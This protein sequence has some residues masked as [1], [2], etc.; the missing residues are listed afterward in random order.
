[1]E[2][3]QRMN[4]QEPNSFKHKFSFVNGITYHYVDEGEE[5]ND[6]II[7]LHGFPD[8]WYGW[9]YQIPYLVSKG[10]RV[11]A[12]DLR[13]YGQTDAPRC[14]PNDLLQYGSKNVSK[15][16][17]E[18]MD[19]LKVKKAIIFGHD[20]GGFLAWRLCI[21]YPERVKAIVSVCTPYIPPNDNYISLES[22]AE[23]L[24][25]LQYQ[26]YLSHPKA[27]IELDGNIERCFKAILRTSTVEDHI[28]LFDG[29]SM[30]GHVIDGVEKSDLISQKELDYYVAQY[31]T[32]GF[33]GGLN[34]YKTRK[35]NFQDEKG[36]RK[37][38][39]HPALMVTAGKDL[40]IHPSTTKNMHKFCKDLSI[41]NIENSGH[42]VMLEQANQLHEYLDEFLEY[43]KNHES[44]LDEKQQH[45]PYY[46]RYQSKENKAKL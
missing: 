2:S 19:Q 43:V 35:V 11:I 45:R 13:G 20:W 7:L 23:I 12:P 32:H 17:K 16:I 8:L 36:T 6:V 27:E 40:H 14:P 24:P 38:I 3:S 15:D 10:Y 4:P 37:Q 1:M 31:K 26:V 39:H 34:W 9:R 29:K 18:L 25:N 33:H 21:H 44:I 41:K 46:Y 5:G 30:M 28:K 42:W 22:V